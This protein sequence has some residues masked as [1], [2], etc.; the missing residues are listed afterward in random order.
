[1]TDQQRQDLSNRVRDLLEQGVKATPDSLVVTPTLATQPCIDA[2]AELARRN[3]DFNIRC[4]TA[5]NAPV[6][7]NKIHS[8]A[9]VLLQ[10]FCLDTLSNIFSAINYSIKSAMEAISHR[11]YSCYYGT[12]SNSS[13][14]TTVQPSPLNTSVDPSQLPESARKEIIREISDAVLELDNQTRLQ[15]SELKEYFLKLNRVLSDA[16]DPTPRIKR[17]ISLCDSYREERDSLLCE[18]IEIGLFDFVIYDV[19]C[20]WEQ[21]RSG[22]GFNINERAYPK[23]KVYKMIAAISLRFG[24]ADIKLPPGIKRTTLDKYI[25]MIQPDFYNQGVESYTT[26][27]HLSDVLDVVSNRIL[28]LQA[29]LA[30]L[31]PVPYLTFLTPDEIH[32][33]QFRQVLVPDKRVNFVEEALNFFRVVFVS[34]PRLSFFNQKIMFVSAV[35]LDSSLRHIRLHQMMYKENPYSNMTL[36]FFTE[37]V[38]EYHCS[39]FTLCD[40][41]YTDLTFELERRSMT[42]SEFYLNFLKLHYTLIPKGSFERDV[43]AAIN[44]AT[45]QLTLV[46]LWDSKLCTLV[47]EFCP[48]E[49]VLHRQMKEF[50]M[51]VENNP[52]CEDYYG[53]SLSEREALA[54]LAN[55]DFFQESCQ[56]FKN[57]DTEIVDLDVEITETE[58]PETLEEMYDKHAPYNLT[59]EPEENIMLIPPHLINKRGAFAGF[60]ARAFRLRFR[61]S[62]APS[63]ASSISSIGR[64]TKAVQ[65]GS[66]SQAGRSPFLTRF[67]NGVRRRFERLTSRMRISRRAHTRCKRS[68]RGCGPPSTT[69]KASKKSAKSTESATNIGRTTP[70]LVNGNAQF[71]STRSVPGEASSSLRRLSIAQSTSLSNQAQTSRFSAAARY[72]LPRTSSNRFSDRVRDLFPGRRA[73]S[74]Q[75]SDSVVRP[76]SM[77]AYGPG[78]N[79]VGEEIAES[80]RRLSQSSNSLHSLPRDVIQP[81]RNI[82]SKPDSTFK[83]AF[84]SFNDDVR[85]SD[86][87]KQR[88]RVRRKSQEGPRSSVTDDLHHEMDRL[89]LNNPS[90]Q[91]GVVSEPIPIPNSHSI[92]GASREYQSLASQRQGWLTDP[93]FPRTR[94]STNWPNDDWAGVSSRLSQNGAPSGQY[95]HYYSAI[96]R[97]SRPTSLNLPEVNRPFPN[98]GEGLPNLGGTRFS[99]SETRTLQRGG[100]PP[101]VDPHVSNW[102]NEQTNYVNSRTGTLNPAG[103]AISK[104]TSKQGTRSGLSQ[105]TYTPRPNNAPTARGSNS[106]FYQTRT[107]DYVTVDGSRIVPV[108]PNTNNVLD[109]LP[110]TTLTRKP[111]KSSVSAPTVV[112]QPR[113]VH[114]IGPLQQKI[115]SKDWDAL[116]TLQ[117][118]EYVVKKLAIYGPILAFT[119]LMAVEQGYNIK[120]MQETEGLERD[121]FMVDNHTAYANLEMTREKHEFDRAVDRDTLWFNIY[122]KLDPEGKLPAHVLQERVRNFTNMLGIETARPDSIAYQDAKMGLIEA[123][124]HINAMPQSDQPKD[125]LKALMT[126]LAITREFV[127]QMNSTDSL[128]KDELLDYLE[129]RWDGLNPAYID[130]I[131]SYPQS[132]PTDGIWMNLH[133]KTIRRSYAK[134]LIDKLSVTNGNFS[135]DDVSRLLNLGF[136]M[137]GKSDHFVINNESFR[138]NKDKLREAWNKLFTGRVDSLTKFK[139]KFSDVLEELRSQISRLM[140]S[141]KFSKINNLKNGLAAMCEIGGCLRNLRNSLVTRTFQY[142]RNYL[143]S[144]DP[145][146]YDKRTDPRYLP[147]LFMTLQGIFRWDNIFNTPPTNFPIN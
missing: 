50:D 82:F 40:R 56:N 145:R 77:N 83:R 140:P 1:M 44:A 4:T 97:P 5:D 10:I 35:S 26:T 87:L 59:Y 22:N 147:K 134:K 60:L 104:S 119:A 33:L 90:L 54:Y 48:E 24:N 86:I 117:K 84:R 70:S 39:F 42:N 52:E 76:E 37:Q 115:T 127:E 78:S 74:R 25:E 123:T 110:R 75:A 99:G 79:F 136:Q 11:F 38:I 139:K 121:R 18:S 122:N 6:Q 20:D 138:I 118:G 143:S 67:R 120:K 141:H 128:I 126:Q 109:S 47:D 107:H 98:R 72:L 66:F 31:D 95:S 15:P 132:L 111:A 114:S 91:P 64:A 101:Q 108:T 106:E 130:L 80:M 89:D 32:E 96:S 131:N 34:P 142:Q 102:V 41:I 13:V 100:T 68:G 55:T 49:A 129:A 28:M 46:S 105:P 112:E 103:G 93:I 116:G 53:F 43:K 12:T 58:P 137:Y 94:A 14:T 135:A 21:T 62:F 9:K 81:P 73:L 124:S 8:P 17:S 61:T 113:M 63:R 29:Y 92:A 36:Q 27:S 7:L 51:P 30:A 133:N 16:Y 45:Y 146:N 88:R 2:R 3:E 57:F 125:H 69:S 85:G 71:L 65:T 19:S 23:D 144:H